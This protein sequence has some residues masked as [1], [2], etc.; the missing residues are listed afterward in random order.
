MGNRLYYK[1]GS[2]LTEDRKNFLKKQSELLEIVM[3]YISHKEIE[4]FNNGVHKYIEKKQFGGKVVEQEY[5]FHV[6][7]ITNKIRKE[8]RKTLSDAEA[9]EVIAIL[10]EALNIEEVDQL[11]EGNELVDYIFKLANKYID[12]YK[13]EIG[14]RRLLGLNKNKDTED[15]IK[16]EAIAKK[17]NQREKINGNHPR[18]YWLNVD[19]TG[20]EWSFSDIKIGRSQTYSN[21]NTN[22][23]RRKNEG[24]F[25]DIQ[26]GDLAVGYETGNL[27][28][29]TTTCKVKNKYIENDGIFVEFQKIHE[30]EIPLDLDLLKESEDLQD[31]EVVHFHRGTLFELE[32]VHFEAIIN[33]L[34]EINTNTESYDEELYE[35]VKQSLQDDSKKRT[36][37]LKNRISSFPVSYETTTRVFQRNPDV[38]AEV[39][40]RANGICEKCNNKA[41]FYRASD[42]TPYLEVH[43]LIRLA[44]GGEDTVENAIAVCPNCHKELHFG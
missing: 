2:N 33:N 3:S 42:G 40:I 11:L 14:M 25:T 29:I 1:S 16:E 28:A 27:K 6:I 44:D 35:A 20:Y 32:K 24:C 37:R 18:Y 7:S 23:Y 36:Q 8:S 12:F 22:G 5:H 38:I 41:P 13:H 43:H 15:L 34:D 39:L 17:V 21:L 10:K 9:W 19:S 30:F 26:I 31:C 4:R